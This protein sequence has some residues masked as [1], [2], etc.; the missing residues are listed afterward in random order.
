ME[1]R[2]GAEWARLQVDLTAMAAAIEASHS[3]GTGHSLVWQ[4]KLEH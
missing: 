3:G 1:W 4:S 2:N